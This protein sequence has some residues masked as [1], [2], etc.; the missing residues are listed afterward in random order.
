MPR[1]ADQYDI[2]QGRDDPSLRMATEIDAGLPGYFDPTEWVLMP[3]GV[4]QLYPDM[5]EDIAARGF[6]FYQL[7]SE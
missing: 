3:P 5:D 1:K 7:V 6:C 4:S 2:Y